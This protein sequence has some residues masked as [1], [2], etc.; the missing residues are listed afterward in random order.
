MK[1]QSKKMLF[2]FT[3]GTLLLLFVSS[4][5]VG[6]SPPVPHVPN[7]ETED[8]IEV[9]H[10]HSDDSSNVKREKVPGIVEFKEV[11]PKIPNPMLTVG[12]STMSFHYYSDDMVKFYPKDITF[13]LVDSNTV[14]IAPT[15]ETTIGY[16]YMYKIRG[17]WG[18]LDIKDYPNG[19]IKLA[20][21]L[22]KEMKGVTKEESGID[23]LSVD[24]IIDELGNEIALIID[25]RAY[26][27]ELPDKPA[28]SASKHTRPT[29]KKIFKPGELADYEYRVRKGDTISG[30]C[31]RFGITQ[32]TFYQ[33]NPHVKVDRTIYISEVVKRH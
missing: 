11:K 26:F 23:Y 9:H 18:N 30:L 22:I 17:G 3:E 27:Y 33:L 6:C 21:S 32:N 25:G 8:L 12:N 14:R 19:N 24:L 2:T 28:Q 5:L 20:L 15:E 4:L 16:P 1:T 7:T 29:R 13:T 31:R 10:V